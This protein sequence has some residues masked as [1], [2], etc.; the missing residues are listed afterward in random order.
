MGF[1]C[2][3]Q[4][5]WH[6]PCSAR[7]CTAGASQNRPTQ[8]LPMANSYPI[9][10]LRDALAINRLRIATLIRDLSRLVE[11]LTADIEHEE[12]RS[13]TRNLA[14]LNYPVLARNLR[15]RRDNL[16]ATIVSL[17]VALQGTSKA[18]EKALEDATRFPRRAINRPINPVITGHQLSMDVRNNSSER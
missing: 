17:E 16:G 12:T 7:R 5:D 6:C 13:G 10:T 2:A 3:L 14:D 18:P 4:D 9:E 15:A 8:R 1:M 11:I